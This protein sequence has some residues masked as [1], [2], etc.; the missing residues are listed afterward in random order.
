M[1]MEVIR[2]ATCID[3][4]FDWTS[5]VCYMLRM[6]AGHKAVALYLCHAA[7]CLSGFW[8]VLCR[9]CAHYVEGAARWTN[10]MPTVA[11]RVGSGGEG[12]VVTCGRGGGYPLT[13]VAY[14]TG[15]CG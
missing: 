11:G 2:V 6:T 9:C 13:R 12:R 14:C 4:W 10:A 8:E 3:L 5:G 15:D 1:R 7:A